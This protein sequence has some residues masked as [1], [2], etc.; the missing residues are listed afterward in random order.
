MK[1]T[2]NEMK[3]IIRV[4]TIY[5]TGGGVS[6][7]GQYNEIDKLSNNANVEIREISDF[8]NNDYV[9]RIGGIGPSTEECDDFSNVREMIDLLQQISSCKIA[10]IYPVELGQESSTFTASINANIPVVNFDPAGMRAKPCVDISIFELLKLDYSLSPLVISTT[11][12]EYMSI[13]NR[14]SAKRNEEILRNFVRINNGQAITH[15]SGIVKISTLIQ[16]NIV[17]SPYAILQ[18]M[19]KMS[20]EEWLKTESVK[21]TFIDIKIIKVEEKELTGFVIKYVDFIHN[22]KKYKLILQNETMF[23]L[24]EQKQP[25]YSV[26]DR[27][28]LVDRQRMEGV[29]CGNLKEGMELTVVVLEPERIWKQNLKRAEEIFGYERFKNLII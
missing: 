27:I 10:G 16:N 2:K 9:I 15:C 29:W 17:N 13:H 4:A 26:P 22:S 28:C 5:A 12:H 23:I 18:K 6:L 20:F 11:N 3:D 21:Q 8:N 25:V 14:L 19:I 7:Q 24:D 1:L